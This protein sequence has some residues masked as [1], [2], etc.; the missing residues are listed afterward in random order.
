MANS[1]KALSALLSYPTEEL[2]DAVGAIRKVLYEEALAPCWALDQLENLL[3]EI[4]TLNL[5]ELQERYVFLFDRTRSLSLHLWDWSF[6]AM[7]KP[8]FLS[9]SAS[10]RKRR[11]I[12]WPRRVLTGREN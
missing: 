9:R 12:I 11:L 6:G 7:C 5:Y 2:K 4:G 10:N 1:F 8:G 3:I